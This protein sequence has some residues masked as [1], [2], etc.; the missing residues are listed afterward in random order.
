MSDQT[1]YELLDVTQNSS[2]DEIQDARNRLMHQ[3]SGDRKRL[4]MIEAAYD[5]ILMDRLRLRQEGKIKVPEGIRFPERLVQPLPSAATPPTKQ[6]PQWLVNL[7]DT[8]TQADLLWPAGIFAALSV[9]IFLATQSSAALLQL[10]LAVGMG[11]CIYFLYRK[12]RKFGRAVL[13]SIV[14][15]IV[16]LCLGGIL[17]SLLQAPLLAIGMILEKFISVVTLAILWLIC[18]FLR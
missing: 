17:G 14:G 1:P 2:F 12:E 18:S 10:S 4:E 15:L 13:L 16:G 7:L 5:A 9:P 6:G 8:P 3:Y 11:C